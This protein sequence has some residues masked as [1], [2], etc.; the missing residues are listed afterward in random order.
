MIS[1]RRPFFR[2]YRSGNELYRMAKVYLQE[3][4]FEN[5]YIL[6]LRFLTLFLEKLQQHPQIKSVTPE[7]R[8]ANKTKLSEIM[9]ITEQLKVKLLERYQREY[10]QFLKDQEQERKRAIEEAKRKELDAAKNRTAAASIATPGSFDYVPSAPDLNDL[11]SIVYPNDFPSGT[12]DPSPGLLPGT[13]PSFDRTT[14]PSL[15]F[16]EGGLRRMMIASDTMQ[17]FLAAAAL[18]TSRN[19]ETCGILAGQLKQNQLLVT[20]IIIPKQSGTSDSCTTMNEEELFDLQDQL[21][22]ITLGWIHTHPSQTA[23][24]SSVDLHT[25]AGYQIMMPEALAIVCSPKHEEQGFFSLTTSGLDFI[26]KCNLTGFHPHPDSQFMEAQHFALD[27][28]NKICIVDL[29]VR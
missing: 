9:K 15:S 17:K 3:G 11:D 13:K 18:N 27:T 24:L 29:R 7:M 10:E 1:D 5:S 23:F 8:K 26:S 21:N 16:I 28:T 19:I 14:K 12:H 4:S 20:H 6:F 22:L 2:Y 25:Q